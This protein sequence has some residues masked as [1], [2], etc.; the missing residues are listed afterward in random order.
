MFGYI[1]KITNKINGKIYVGK[2]K[3]D[4]PE[5]DESYWCSGSYIMRSINKYGIENII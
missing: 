4:K 3:Y 5:I 2:H 1:Y